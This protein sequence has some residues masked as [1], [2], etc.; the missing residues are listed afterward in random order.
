MDRD[1]FVDYSIKALNWGR[2]IVWLKKPNLDLL[3]KNTKEVFNYFFLWFFT[4]SNV[5]ESF[6]NVIGLI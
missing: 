5:L 6:F 2:N 4:P 3:D 1:S